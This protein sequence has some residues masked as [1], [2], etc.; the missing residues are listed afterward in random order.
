MV[1]QHHVR[2]VWLIAAALPWLCIAA[3]GTEK[4]AARAILTDAHKGNCIT[5]HVIPI[6]GV[7]ANAFGN[8]GPA[9][10]GV[11]SRLRP[12]QIKARIVDPRPLTPGTIMPAYG[13]VTGLYRVQTDYLGKPILTDAEI[14]MLV[15]YLSALK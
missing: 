14:D 6:S 9:L 1:R 3:R 7:P 4:D 11:G 13:S 12:E 15:A 8:L 10:T 2:H 5:C